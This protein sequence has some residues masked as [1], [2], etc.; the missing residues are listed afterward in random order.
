MKLKI[1]HSLLYILFFVF[2]ANSQSKQKIQFP[3]IGKP[4]PEFTLNNIIDYS[5]ASIGSKNLKG[6]WYILDFWI[7]GCQPC[8][9]SFPEVSAMAEKLKGKVE[10]FSVGIGAEELQKY[11]MPI[12]KKKALKIPMAFD[13]VLASKWQ[14]RSYP[15]I[16]I[17]DDK[18]ILRA[19]TYETNPEKLAILIKTGENQFAK[20][21]NYRQ[22][23][24]NEVTSLYFVNGNGGNDT[25]F[26]FRSVIAK[27]TADYSSNG[28]ANI[29]QKG[30]G[31]GD[32]QYVSA[33]NVRKGLFQMSK[34][35]L[36][37]LYNTA[38]FGQ[39]RAWITD[40]IYNEIVFLPKYA[41]KVL[42]PIL[43]V[44]DSSDFRVNY[45]TLQG[46]FTY[47]LSVPAEKATKDF[48]MRAMQLDLFKF[49]GYEA[50]LEM[51][52]WPVWKLVVSDP[53]QVASLKT[54]GGDPKTS[55]YTDSFSQLINASAF[56]VIS[57][58]FGEH[59]FDF[60]F[61]KT[62]ID[63]KM[64]IKFE[65]SMRDMNTVKRELNKNGFDLVKEDRN[66]KVLV[67][68]DP[69]RK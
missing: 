36:L 22:Y 51:R 59:Q 55:V 57:M 54:Q 66:M 11:Y 69:K 14:V 46:L 12:R 63:Y 15:T 39:D 32:L 23:L 27:A 60:F 35:S 49:F 67:I 45:K 28:I 47:S 56:D 42:W 4:M 65:G 25:S 50:K 6:K 7:M 30:P 2:N 52:K 64:D 58:I 26:L 37:T 18:G 20:N 10:V 41:D 16:F 19:I 61:D 38:F 62:G 21:E 68:S 53:N 48:I 5:T 8:I 40:S 43:N 44:K 3:V 34:T 17:V 31:Y 9:K 13:P 29:N 33:V 1:S 24:Q